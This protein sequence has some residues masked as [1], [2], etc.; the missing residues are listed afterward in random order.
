M[1]NPNSENV[2]LEELFESPLVQKFA[3]MPEEIYAS[4]S[5]SN[6]IV[7]ATVD[8]LKQ[9]E[10]KNVTA[11]SINVPQECSDENEDRVG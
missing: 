7:R 9:A 3:T 2:T 6:A 4:L 11:K 5:T 1:K 10:R 8:V